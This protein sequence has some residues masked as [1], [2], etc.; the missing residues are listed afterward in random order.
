MAE[1]EQS[2]RSAL[3]GAGKVSR[4]VIWNLAGEVAPLLA[5]V[6][7]IPL[8]IHGLGTERFGILSLAWALVG[9][10][11]VLDIGLGR[12]LTKLAVDKLAA[13]ITEEIAGLFWTAFALMLVLSLL[14]GAAMA[15]ASPWLVY[16]ELAI[17]VGL[18]HE[19]L[20]MFY[21]L[22]LSLPLVI[23]TSAFRGLLAALQRF[24]LLNAIR[25]P[26]GVLTFVGP[27]LAIPFSRK[28]VPAVA[29][30]VAVRLCAWL[31]YLFV[32]LRAV[33][34][35]DRCEG[36]L[37]E[38]ENVRP[39]LSF[40]GWITVTSIA[41]PAMLYG[42]RFV[43]AAMLSTAAVAYYATPCDI[44]LRLSILPTAVAG[45]LFTVFADN[46][47]QAD[48][49]RIVSLINR[50]SNLILMM[51][52]P[53]ILLIVTLAPEGLTLWL[54]ANFSAHSALVL[55]WLAV[56]ILINS[57]G[58]HLPFALL[59]AGNRP[60]ITAKLALIEL[61]IYFLLLYWLIRQIGLEGAAIAWSLRLTADAVALWVAARNLLP[62]AGKIAAHIFQMLLAAVAAIAVGAM[63]PSI[64][65]LK[66]MF[67]GFTLS[68]YGL[69]SWFYLLTPKDRERILV[70]LRSAYDMP[71]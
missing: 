46:F 48:P 29:V 44:V 34:G 27:L 54:G 55:R 53:A 51:M 38:L 14:G 6:V 32:C 50:G 56:G 45:V 16:H 15:A 36:P 8:L 2:E 4:N 67:L 11:S 26:L 9:Y 13:G 63:L 12:A 1:S 3:T 33:P 30:L 37:L 61:P 25:V 41:V 60:D 5:A 10:L 42:D 21:L 23:T 57:L 24:D 49:D 66:A 22:S 71:T 58:G 52:F 20:E 17:P 19:G 68:G 28:L 64:V 40:G 69:M 43:I 47:A 62:R 59:Q 18:R 35:L 65:L 31:T 39:L 70:G 7:S